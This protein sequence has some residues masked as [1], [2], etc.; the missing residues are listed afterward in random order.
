MFSGGNFKGRLILFLL[1]LFLIFFSPDLRAQNTGESSDQVRNSLVKGSKSFQFRISQNLTLSSFEGTMI[2]AKKHYSSK[3]ALRFGIGLDIGAGNWDQGT[4]EA[5]FTDFQIDFTMQY[6]YYPS[7]LA[8][9]N[10]Y[11]GTGP[12]VEYN[13]RKDDSKNEDG[14]DAGYRIERLW[15]LGMLGSWGVEWFADEN[16]SFICEYGAGI[17][18]SSARYENYLNPIPTISNRDE[19]LFF[20]QSVDFGLSVYF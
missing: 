8:S 18:Y 16:I 10:F 19:F 11:I 2:S 7:P 3:S 15:A 9:V 1:P 17:K 5:D 13:R 20:S 4:Q 12:I 6:L 14:T